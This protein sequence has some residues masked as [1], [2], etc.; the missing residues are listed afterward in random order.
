MSRKDYI[1]KYVKVKQESVNVFN[2]GFCTN[3]ILGVSEERGIEE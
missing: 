3:V 1:L 2:K